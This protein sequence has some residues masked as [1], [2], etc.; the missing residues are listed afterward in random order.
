MM[1]KKQIDDLTSVIHHV[2]F[3]F[4]P[5]RCRELAEAIYKADYRKVIH[6]KWLMARNTGICSNC[7]RQDTLDNLACYCRYCGADMRGE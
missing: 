2:L 6:A 3:S 1:D 5:E 7:N 4:R